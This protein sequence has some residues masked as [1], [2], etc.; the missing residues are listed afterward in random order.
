MSGGRF[1]YKQYDLAEEI[2]GYRLHVDYGE[3]GF[4]QAPQ[5]ARMN[6]LH[7]VEMSEM[8]WDMICVVHSYD[9]WASGD[10]GEERYRADV[11]H[12]KEKWLGKTP[13]QRTNKMIQDAMERAKED[14]EI[15]FGE[16]NEE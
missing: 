12:F 3:E 8:L 14:A 11:K 1:N 4:S 9:W 7:D 10:N 6:P 16:R 5:A 2:F 15:A 13:T